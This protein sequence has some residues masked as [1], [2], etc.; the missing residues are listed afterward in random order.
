MKRRHLAFL[1]L[2]ILTISAPVS[3]FGEAQESFAEE[4]EDN[5]SKIASEDEKI[6]RTEVEE[7]G[8][9]PITADGVAEGSYMVDVESSSSMFNIE[10]ALLTV[11]DGEMSAILTMGGKG[12]L[13]LYMGTPEEAAAAPEEDYI[14]FVENNE[15]KHTYTVPVEAL[16]KALDCAAFS[17]NKEK[18]YD[19]QILFHASSIPMESLLSLEVNT[20]E[21]LGLEDG[22]YTM[23][24]SLSG[25]SGR[26][27]VESPATITV[28]DGQ[29]AATIVWGSENYDY[30]LVDGEKYLNENEGGLSTFTIPVAAFDYRM[31]VTADT[32]AMSKPHEIDYTLTFDSASL[33]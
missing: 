27:S 5:S 10:S 16:D 4:A 6:E 22:T 24:V 11:K 19:R 28:T 33:K 14:P 20:V 3:S 8:M 7:E 26:A 2:L 9:V 30:M 12:Y 23:D 13:Y 31:P 25:G 15:G 29:A 1:S 32:V 21:S 18:W 17:K